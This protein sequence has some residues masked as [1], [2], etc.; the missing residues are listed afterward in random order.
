MSNNPIS[1]I[2]PSYKK[3]SEVVETIER[4]EAVLCER[5]I[6]HEIILVIDGDVDETFRKVSHLNLPCLRIHLLPLN[7]GKGAA[8]MFGWERANYPLVGYLDCD[9]DIHP[10]AVVRAYMELESNSNL[11]GIV[12]TKIRIDQNLYGFSIRKVLSKAYIH[13]SRAMLKFHMSE[14]QTGMK[15][16]RKESIDLLLAH[17]IQN[18][19]AWDLEICSL[20]A[21]LKLNID[22][23]QV[24]VKTASL[25]K[26]SLS[27][28]TALTAVIDIFKIRKHLAK[29]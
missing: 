25:A 17:S 22:E 15:V 18:G 1:I 19:F 26:S 4:L 24:E 9:L 28:K 20:A 8:V 2:L 3:A 21:L 12:G 11:D 7:Q 16:F 14:T 5:N 6:P 29:L 27:W 10:T 23:I 13:L